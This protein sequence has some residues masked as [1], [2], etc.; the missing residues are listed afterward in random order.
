MFALWLP[1]VV[2]T[3]V[4]NNVG[5]SVISLILGLGDRAAVGV[6]GIVR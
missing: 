3:M 4:R 1:A 5:S 2:A 6:E